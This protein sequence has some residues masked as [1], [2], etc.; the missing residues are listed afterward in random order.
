MCNVRPQTTF[1]TGSSEMTIREVIDLRMKTKCSPNRE[2]K[3]IETWSVFVQLKKKQSFTGI[4]IAHVIK[5]FQTSVRLTFLL[6]TKFSAG[7]HMRSNHRIKRQTKCVCQPTKPPK[8]FIKNFYQVWINLANV[9]Q[10]SDKNLQKRSK[11]IPNKPHTQ[12]DENWWLKNVPKILFKFRKNVYF[13]INRSSRQ[14]RILLRKKAT[15]CRK[16]KTIKPIKFCRIIILHVN[17]NYALIFRL[18]NQDCVQCVG[19]LSLLL[20][21]WFKFR[22]IQ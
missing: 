7:G 8:T 3:S 13:V 20:F 22:L 5:D 14:R 11:K 2:Q 16:A 17:W 18:S 1:R 4:A 12:L 15:Y 6:E 21:V 10:E 19:L 9:D